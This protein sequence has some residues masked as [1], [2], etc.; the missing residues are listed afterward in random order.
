MAWTFPIKSINDSYKRIKQIQSDDPVWTLVFCAH[1]EEDYLPATIDSISKISTSLPI[2]I[3]AINNAST[4]RTREI[5]ALSWIK[6]FDEEEKG[7]SYARDMSLKVAKGDIIFQTDA[8]TLIPPTWIDAHYRHYSDSRIVWVSGWI[9]FDRVHKLYHL[10][11][12]VWVS[13]WISF[14]R[15]HKLYHLYRIW[16]ITLYKFLELFWRENFNW[17]ANLS[18]RKDIATIS[19]WFLKWANNWEDRLLQ[20][21]LVKHWIIKQV[22]DD[23]I[24]VITSWRR[25]NDSKRIRSFIITRLNTLFKTALNRWKVLCDEDFENIR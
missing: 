18:Y 10:S 16:A 5:L 24:N 15:V 14:D 11:R 12:I 13:G 6:V 22:R 4:D 8:D 1:N 7:I 20:L 9:S 17:W 25:M 23:S 19:W 2:E 3:I 21:N